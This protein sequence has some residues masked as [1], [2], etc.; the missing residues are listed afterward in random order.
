MNLSLE[1]C[2]KATPVL[3]LLYV[4]LGWFWNGFQHRRNSV[5]K[6]QAHLVYFK[7]LQMLVKAIG[8]KECFHPYLLI[9]GCTLDIFVIPVTVGT[10]L[11]LLQCSK[12]W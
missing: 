4:G 10:V 9:W 1:S 8:L 12:M 3:N 7:I 2:N 5:V 6:P 11:H